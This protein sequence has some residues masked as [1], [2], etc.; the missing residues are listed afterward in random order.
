MYPKM[1]KSVE[2]KIMP[3]NDWLW[4]MID[5]CSNEDDIKLPF[6]ILQK[7]I[8]FVSSLHIPHTGKIF[9][10]IFVYQVILPL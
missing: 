7:L 2:G 10:F 6:Q 4:S 8:V 3:L 9:H 5:R 1:L